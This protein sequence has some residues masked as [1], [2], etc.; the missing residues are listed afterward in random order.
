MIVLLIGL[1]ST[2]QNDFKFGAKEGFNYSG[3]NV[4]GSSSY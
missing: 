4:G 1:N 3:F 2:A